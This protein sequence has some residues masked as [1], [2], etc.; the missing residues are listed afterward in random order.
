MSVSSQDPALGYNNS[1][2]SFTLS[3]KMKG[4]VDT[5]WK[6]VHAFKPFTRYPIFR[7]LNLFEFIKVEN[8]YANLERAIG[9]V[10]SSLWLDEL[11]NGKYVMTYNS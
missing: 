7:Y 11:L 8:T 2:I 1:L 3:V 9:I 6:E 4:R 10:N 5:E